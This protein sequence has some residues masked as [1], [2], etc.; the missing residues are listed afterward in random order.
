MSISALC[1]DGNQTQ[2]LVHVG[3]TLCQLNHPQLL[4]FH[5]LPKCFFIRSFEFPLKKSLVYFPVILQ[6]EQKWRTKMDIE[7]VLL[8]S[9]S[10]SSSS[11][12]SSSSSS[13][14][15]SS[16]SSSSSFL[17]QL[18][19]TF[20]FIR[21]VGTYPSLLSVIIWIIIFHFFILTIFNSVMCFLQ[22]VISWIFLPSV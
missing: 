4:L 9:S 2:G 11:F 17:F 12:S 14:S 5:S 22:T 7:W 19:L 1:G 3:Q 20:Y 15:F 6:G 13:S 8:L 21:C 18:W 10:S 16:S